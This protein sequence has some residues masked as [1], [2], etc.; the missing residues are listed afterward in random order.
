MD[1]R[2][3]YY[4]NIYSH[5]LVVPLQNLNFI[6]YEKNLRILFAV[7]MIATCAS[8]AKATTTSY[9]G[10]LTISFMGMPIESEATVSIITTSDS[11]CTFSL[12]NFSFQGTS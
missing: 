10:K 12:P 3:L 4:I 6:A 2:L 1:N 7:V 11:T 9:N 8:S 5:N